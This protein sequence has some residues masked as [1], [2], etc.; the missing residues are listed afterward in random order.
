MVTGDYG[1]TAESIARKIGIVQGEDLRIVTG[2]QLAQMS[3][4]E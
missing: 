4:A 2:D 3:D 1:L